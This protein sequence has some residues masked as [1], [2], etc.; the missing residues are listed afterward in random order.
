MHGDRVTFDAIDTH[1]DLISWSRRYCDRAVGVYGFAVDLA[2]VEWTVST[3][4]R[5]RAAA[6]SHPSIPDANAGEAHDSAGRLPACTVSLTW[7]AYES[8]SRAEWRGL[9]RHELIHVEQFQRTG[10]TH[11][12]PGF[13]E[14]AAAVDA[15]EDCPSFADPNY[16]LRCGECEAVVARRFRASRPVTEPAAYRSSCCGSP[17]SVDS[18]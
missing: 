17:L 1:E 8:V 18:V 9:L 4:A 2:R 10:T 7:P 14:R 3:R 5:R 13:S 15:T 11:H 6:V 12:G 16:L